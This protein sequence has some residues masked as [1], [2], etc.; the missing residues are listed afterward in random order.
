MFNF[1]F[2]ILGRVFP[3]M[4]ALHS[5]QTGQRDH[6]L[7]W[8]CYFCINDLWLFTEKLFFQFLFLIPGY[9]ELRLLALMV[10]LLLIAGF[11]PKPLHVYMAF[12]LNDYRIVWKTWNRLDVAL[13]TVYDTFVI[14][15]NARDY[16]M[17]S[18]FSSHYL[19]Q[20]FANLINLNK[21]D[22]SKKTQLQGTKHD[23]ESVQ[24]KEILS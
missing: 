9:E 10:L 13:T 1:I 12:I 4:A 18:I 6:S 22:R 8:L 2:T 14:K 15:F 17:G 19:Q 16:F 21:S 11:S 7:N 20:I 3:L 5:I 24:N 23:I